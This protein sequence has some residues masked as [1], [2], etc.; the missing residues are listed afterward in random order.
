MVGKQ[1]DAKPNI[2]KIADLRNALLHTKSIAYS[3][4]DSGRYVSSQ[5]F[6]KLGI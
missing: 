3:D 4:S 2:K 1:G 6:K 5:L